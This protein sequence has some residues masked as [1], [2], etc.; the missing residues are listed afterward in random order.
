MTGTGDDIAELR[1]QLAE[2]EHRTRNVFTVITAMIDLVRKDGDAATYASALRARTCALALSY[3]LTHAEGGFAPLPDLAS[4]VLDPFAES[5]CV[6]ITLPEVA[7]STARAARAVTQILYE[8]AINAAKH[9]AL[10]TE[11]GRLVLTAERTEGGL[12]I[13][14]TERCDP[15]RPAP[16]TRRSGVGTTLTDALASHAGCSI[17]REWRRE[18]LCARIG[19]PA[20]MLACEGRR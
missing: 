15:V 19:I 6:A 12:L 10:R 7:L 16:P 8:F 14:W 9:G 17:D 1:L 20:A 3:E 4:A 11:R 5:G 13:V 2:L 18:G